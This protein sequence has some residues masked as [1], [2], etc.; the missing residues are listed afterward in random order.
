MSGRDV[1]QTPAEQAEAFAGALDRGEVV[2]AE[3]LCLRWW[4]AACDVG[5]RCDR[6]GEPMRA[7]LR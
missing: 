1:T 2:F 7:V 3:C 4:L 5:A 6:C